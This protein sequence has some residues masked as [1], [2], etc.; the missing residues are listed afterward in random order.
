MMEEAKIKEETNTPDFKRVLENF[1]REIEIHNEIVNSIEIKCS[2]LKE[3]KI[4]E[5]LVIDT[6][7]MPRANGIIG[8]LFQKIELLALGNKQLSYINEHLK[9]I[10]G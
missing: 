4:N 1:N 10:T 9:S 2:M 7:S 5:L 8:E 3:I 6:S